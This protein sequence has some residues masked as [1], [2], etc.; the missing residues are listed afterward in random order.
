MKK[1]KKDPIES[2][3]AFFKILPSVLLIMIS[4]VECTVPAY[5]YDNVDSG[6]CG[7]QDNVLRGPGIFF[8]FSN[9]LAHIRGIDTF[10]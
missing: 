9:A 5:D 7:T 4:Q 8:T 6:R 10:P 1:E 3:L 2:D